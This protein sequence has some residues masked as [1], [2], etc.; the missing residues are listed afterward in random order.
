MDMCLPVYMIIENG[1]ELNG[2]LPNR[3]VREA[4]KLAVIRKWLYLCI[5]FETQVQHIKY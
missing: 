5:A 2:S 4:E 1:M 3:T